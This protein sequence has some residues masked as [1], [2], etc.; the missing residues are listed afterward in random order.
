MTRL[1]HALRYRISSFIRRLGGDSSGLALIEF[2]YVLPIM[3]TISMT[4]AELTNYITTKMRVSQLALQIADNAS[5]IGTDT[6]LSTKQ[7]SEAQIN[8][9]LTGAG[10]QSGTLDLF[11][12]GRVIVSSLQP[13]ANPNTTN[14]FLI[15]WQRCRG[16]KAITSS[17]G[18]EG[19]TDLDGITANGQLI[20]APDNGAVIFVQISYDY[21]PIIGLSF[22]K[23]TAINEVA[24]MTVRDDRDT[25]TVYNTENVTPSTC[26][27]YS[28]S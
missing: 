27:T 26:N 9:M 1:G 5:R 13:V 28:A 22:T 20:T 4:G 16:V 3:V 6:V 25:S 23:L 15:E 11:A 18:L 8:D 2:A 10:L 14:R 7:I 21:Q 24:A 17:Y 19:D 12:H